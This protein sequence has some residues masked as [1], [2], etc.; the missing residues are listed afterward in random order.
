MTDE[1]QKEDFGIFNWLRGEEVM[2]CA[3]EYTK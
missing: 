2:H 1:A 3:G